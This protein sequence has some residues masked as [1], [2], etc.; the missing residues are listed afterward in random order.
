M[1]ILL[2]PKINS[3]FNHTDENTTTEIVEVENR[4]TS[5]T[6]DSVLDGEFLATN[7]RL[8]IWQQSFNS[9]LESP[10]FG[11]GIYGDRLEIGKRWY[12]GYSHNIVLELMNHFGIIGLVFFCFLFYSVIKKIITSKEHA[13]RLLYIIVLS[14]CAK[15][16]LSDSYLLNAYFWML[17]GLLI[18]DSKFIKR[19]SNRKIKSAS[20]TI[21]ILSIL[22]SLLFLLNDYRNQDFKTIKF[23][24]PTAIISTTNTNIDTFSIYQTI[25]EFDYKAV[26]FISASTITNAEVG[27]LTIDEFIRMNDYNSTFEDGEF[28]YQNPYIRPEAIQVENRIKTE[29]FF[30]EHDLEK[31][32]AYAPPFGA[33]NSTIEYR[34]M[35]DYSFIQV[36]KSETKPKPINNITYPGSLNIQARQLYWKNE[37]EKTDL[38]QYIK[39]AKNEGSLIILNINTKNYDST[40]VIEILTLLKDNDFESITYKDLYGAAKLSSENISLKNYIENTYLYNYIN[41]YL[42]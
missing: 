22:S 11:K 39:K 42:R 38:I 31:P 34:C 8:K 1:I 27:K 2:I 41:K 23:S 17:I 7:G 28:I 14:L 18:V 12:W 10:I 24:K 36:N 30:L 5:R 21:L 26:Y 15:L 33:H 25:Q 16:L 37:A 32:I 20:I 40:Q 9:F 3:F 13:K 19:L 29:E 4:L 35:N 6:M